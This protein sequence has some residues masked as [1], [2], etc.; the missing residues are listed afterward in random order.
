[1]PPI[2]VCIPVRNEARALPGLFASLAQQRRRG[3]VVAMAFD[4][5]EDDSE[6]IAIDGAAGH[7]LDIRHVQLPRQAA[8]DAGRARRSALELG[9]RIVGAQGILL[10]TDADT[11]PASDW[12]GASD[13]A[14]GNA[15][16]VCGRI[17]RR[18][19]SVDRWRDVIER[20]LD[21]LHAVHRAI[22]PVAGDAVP[23]H[24]HSGGASLGLSARAWDAIAHLALPST[25]EDRAIVH[26]ARL[27]GL[28]VRQD[29]AVRVRTSS[30][31]CG[32]AVGGL[33]DALRDGRDQAALRIEPRMEHPDDV[34]ARVT[35]AAIAR[36]AFPITD[37]GAL[38]SRIGIPPAV[39]AAAADA[40]RSADAFVTALPLILGPHRSVPLGEASTIL[41]RHEA[42]TGAC[43]A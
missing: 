32:R 27:A 2:A 18:R 34:I 21:R 37:A 16:L 30:R 15:D 41:S 28:V 40:A 3:F 6:R 13:R 11:R 19:D 1:M 38:A 43:A 5:C 8:A 22:D 14:L 10:T 36:R 42:S 4:G 39:I 17:E 25:G 24:W 12:I 9:R 33:A 31:I 23:S 7:A 29:P 26:A 35:R 20:Y